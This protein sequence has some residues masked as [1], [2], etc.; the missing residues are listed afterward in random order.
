M[1]KRTTA[2]L[3]QSIEHWKYNLRQAKVGR[4]D[5]IKYSASHCALCR[6][7]F[8]SELRCAGC[9][10]AA[11]S[12]HSV[13]RETPYVEVVAAIENKNLSLEEAVQAQVDFLIS[14]R[15]D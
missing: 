13:C 15:E 12:G 3:E 2:A 7:F 9:P 10:V 8:H 6:L 14:L 11:A 1:D 4:A 5:K